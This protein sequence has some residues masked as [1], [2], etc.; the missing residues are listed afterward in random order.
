MTA[1]KK[2]GS[3]EWEPRGAKVQILSEPVEITAQRLGVSYW[4]NL[5]TENLDA[6]DVNMD[7]LSL[8][9]IPYMHNEDINEE[10][11]PSNIDQYSSSI[12]QFL[13]GIVDHIQTVN[14]RVTVW[15][16]SLDL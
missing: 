5:I 2:D 15:H 1:N 16:Q 14:H 4:L 11:D 8:K 13:Q 10:D 6:L 3:E 7:A 12:V 9:F